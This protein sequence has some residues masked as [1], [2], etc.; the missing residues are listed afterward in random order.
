MCDVIGIWRDGMGWDGKAKHGQSSDKLIFFFEGVG[1]W[2]GWFGMDPSRKPLK[3][4]P[5]AVSP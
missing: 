2:L 4:R 1:G 3:V 5:P